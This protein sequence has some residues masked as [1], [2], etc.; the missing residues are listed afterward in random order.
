M[1]HAP[2]VAGCLLSWLLGAVVVRLGLDWADTF[3]YSAASE[4]RYL[5]VAVV[6]LLVAIGGSVTTLLV[7]RRRQRR[8]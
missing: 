4:R 3:P 1:R 7:A 6:A 8:D 2:V 5:G